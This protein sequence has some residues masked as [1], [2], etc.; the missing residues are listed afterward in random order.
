MTPVDQKN[1]QEEPTRP[2][3]F[4]ERMLR[5][6][7][8]SVAV[9]LCVLAAQSLN[10]T[11]QPNLLSQIVS[12]DLSESLGSLRF[13]SN[14]L[15]DSAAVFWNL[16]AERHAQPSEAMVTHAFS[17]QEPWL[18]YAAG[19][20]T[21]TAAGEVMSVSADPL[22]RTTIRVRHAS[23]METLYGNLLLTNVREGD[24]VETGD[25]LGAAKALTYELR[26]EGR[27]MNPAPFQ[28]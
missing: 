19:E 10:T 24:W 13:V 25:L 27:A 5:N 26:G 28:Q 17:S 22:G 16:G 12:M 15:P 20:V 8:I 9:L 21:A 3:G 7:A 11:G 2:L 1:P 4:G 18:E 23:G 14:F 6:T